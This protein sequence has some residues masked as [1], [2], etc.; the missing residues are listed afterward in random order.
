MLGMSVGKLLVLVLIIVGVWY[1][2]KLFSRLES[3]RK[4]ELK[5][6]GRKP[7]RKGPEAEEM[8]S[9]PVCGTYV[10]SSNAGSC[11]RPDCP[12]PSS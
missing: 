4:G 6:E 3:A 8:V 1:G 11:G 12:Y 9:C 10:P 7:A 2:F 5:D